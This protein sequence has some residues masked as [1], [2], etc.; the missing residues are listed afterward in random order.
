MALSSTLF[1]QFLRQS[2]STSNQQGAQANQN[3]GMPANF[4]QAI[5]GPNRT[6]Q[7]S[8][9]APAINTQAQAQD[10]AR[11]QAA[12][13]PT[14][15]GGGAAFQATAEDKARANVQ[16]LLGNMQM[17]AVPELAGIG[18]TNLQAMLD[19]LKSGMGAAQADAASR[20]AATASMIDALITG[21]GAIAGAE[22]GK[23]QKPAG[24]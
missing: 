13:A 14:R 19:S 7:M 4:L 12:S 8:A 20:R 2:A 22:L 24:V 6:A 16:T 3:L 21:G 9:I 15:T 5:L 23:V 10:A 17:A 11:N 18:K 1:D